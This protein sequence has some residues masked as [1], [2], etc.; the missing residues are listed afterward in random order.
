MKGVSGAEKFSGHVNFNRTRYLKILREFQFL[1]ERCRI[2]FHSR[3]NLQ[4][5]G[6]DTGRQFPQSAFKSFQHDSVV[7]RKISGSLVCPVSSPPIRRGVVVL[8]SDGTIVDVRGPLEKEEANIEYYNG[9][10]IPGFVNA[11]CHI[12][13]SHLKGI[14]PTLLGM[15]GFI[16]TITE[17]RVA[18]ESLID[19]AIQWAD[20]YM[21]D[22]GI[23]LV[24]DVSNCAA[25]LR[26]KAN[27]KITYH[28]FVEAFASD[29]NDAKK[30][31][32]EK[33]TVIEAAHRLNLLASLTLHAPYSISPQLVSAFTKELTHK[34]IISL[35]L[36]E[37]QEEIDYMENNAGP[38]AALYKKQNR[39]ESASN[40]WGEN[41]YA[42][43]FKSIPSE[44][45]MLA[46]HSGHI[47]QAYLD[48]LRNRFMETWFVLCPKSNQFI[49][50][51]LPPFEFFRRNSEQIA[52]GT[53]SLASN[54]TLSILEE[55]K[56]IGHSNIPFEEILK[57]ATL[58]GARALGQGS[59]FGSFD[60]N[61]KPG[62][63]LLTGID[64]IDPILSEET[65]VRRLL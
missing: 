1:H 41:P 42:N 22:S 53:D 62:V 56:S 51:E 38:L 28:T 30:V 33:K 3:I 43:I 45:K 18:D 10:L 16:E 20:S 58:N 13:L 63:L 17:K 39:K 21:F 11:H 44:N 50:N 23:S 14:F 52:L 26:T 27:S 64:T 36:F 6:I 65:K 60:K 24:G 5:A 19:Q 12:E 47:T 9:I 7:M 46:I 61:K 40:H 25:T 37:S 55:M 8:D 49:H 54:T 15:A 29:R 48:L 35:H 57:W 2:Y 4:R 59:I 32:D 34:D 31:I